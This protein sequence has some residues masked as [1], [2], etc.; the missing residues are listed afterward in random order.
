MLA[1]AHQAHLAVPPPPGLL[2]RL[3]RG[4]A[5]CVKVGSIGARGTVLA[6]VA[7]ALVNVHLAVCACGRGHGRLAQSHKHPYLLEVCSQCKRGAISSN[8]TVV[9]IVNLLQAPSPPPGRCRGLQ[10][11][12]AFIRIV[13][14]RTYQAERRF[15]TAAVTTDMQTCSMLA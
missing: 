2:A 15:R 9:G 10:Q 3:R 6:G 7:V 12:S 14:R 8:E 13:P 4:A 5:T 1:A 11:Q